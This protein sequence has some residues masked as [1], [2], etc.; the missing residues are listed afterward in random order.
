MFPNTGNM[1]LPLALFAFGNEG[2]ALAVVYFACTA[3]LQF[4]LGISLASG[5]VSIRRLLRTPAIYAVVISLLILTLDLDVPRW[6]DNSLAVLGGLTI[7][8]ML[9]TLG[10]SLAQL[11]V[12]AIGRNASLAVV[13]LVGG[14]I[15]GVVVA[16][17]FDL[18]RVA[19]G[20]LI[21][22]SAMPVAVFNFLFAKQYGRAHTDVAAMIVISTFLSFVTLPILVFFVLQ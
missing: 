22:Q 1:G 19:A 20:V 18:P 21:I 14:L 6:A 10:V 17:V 16:S 3:T 12:A 9:L 5:S 8:L 7:P 13:R 15:V 11:H 4:T 2:L